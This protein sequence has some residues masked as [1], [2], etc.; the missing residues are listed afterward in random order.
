VS[1]LHYF[2]ARYYDPGVCLWHGTDP[3]MEKYPGWSPYNYCMN[4]PVIL[5]D[6]DGKDPVTSFFLFS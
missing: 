2:G 5:I 6:P 1:G 4:N 3:M